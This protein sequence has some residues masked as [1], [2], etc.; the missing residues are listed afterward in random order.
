MKKIFPY[1]ITLNQEITAINFT[2]Y[3]KSFL[4]PRNLYLS[5]SDISMFDSISSFNPFLSGTITQKNSYPPFQ[6]IVVPEFTVLADKVLIF[7]F[8]EQ[9]KTTGFVDVIMENEAGY[10]KLT[11]DTLLPFISSFRGAENIQFPWISGIQIKN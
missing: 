7:N 2:I 11:T 8:P 1:K 6:G 9:P 5:A 10:G 3:G 4:N